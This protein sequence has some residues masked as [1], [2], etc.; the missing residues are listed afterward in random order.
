MISGKKPVIDQIR[1]RKGKMMYGAPCGGLGSGTIGRGFRGEFCRWQIVPGQCDYT[2]V[3]ADQF[4]V[5]VHNSKGDCV[6]QSVL[7]GSGVPPRGAPSSWEW[8]VNPD[9]CLYCA[10]YPRSRRYI[11]ERAKQIHHLCYETSPIF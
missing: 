3:P 7:G 4:L 8:R 11:K 5:T 9:D 6:Y 1:P 2:S 10:L